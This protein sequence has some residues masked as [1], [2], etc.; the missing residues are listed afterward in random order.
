M[1]DRPSDHVAAFEAARPDLRTRA[2]RMLGSWADADDVVQ[3]TWE[4]WDR[5]D[6]SD[7][8]EPAAWLTT[9]SSRLA[10][11]QLRRRKRDQQY[12]VGPWL[13][14]PLVSDRATS[15]IGDPEAAA[16][17]ADSLTLGF[18]VMLE[19]LTPDE[20]AAFLMADVFSEPYAIIA[21]R[22]DR[23][24]ESCRQL[25][26]RARRKVAD[27]GREDRSSVDVSES[28]VAAF[29]GAL[30]AGDETTALACLDD[31]V[32]LVSDGGA[33]RRAA[34]RPVVG[35]ERVN[36]FLFNMSKR[37]DPTWAVDV[38]DVG[39]LP[40]TVFTSPAG[41]E[42]VMAFGVS[43]GRVAEIF[44]ILNPDKLANISR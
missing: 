5:A 37:L 19:H 2:Y 28:V 10:I 42:M 6:R 21:E 12:Y 22:L 24:V 16:E 34:R 20:R 44:S 7:V 31:D 26:S 15:T 35:A 13:P 8:A 23:S 4:R 3:T 38:A 9:V 25:A 33:K 32:V 17:L 11:D 18:L 40:G 30:V 36:R 1:T 14:E 43:D 39:G 41:V 27:R 29:L